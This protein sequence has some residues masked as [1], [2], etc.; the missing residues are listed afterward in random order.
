MHQP[1]PPIDS[2][3]FLWA[4]HIGRT[5]HLDRSSFHR[6]LAGVSP[7]VEQY[8]KG[9]R[10]GRILPALTTLAILEL[11]VSAGSVLS[12]FDG[13]TKLLKV[14]ES[15]SNL[16][17]VFPRS[18]VLARAALILTLDALLLTEDPP[19]NVEIYVR[20]LDAELAAVDWD[21]LEQLSP[22]RAMQIQQIEEDWTPSDVEG[23]EIS[24]DR[25]W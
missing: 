23:N 3:L 1:S 6:Q 17:G 20:I 22:D 18:T 8:A 2:A 10:S 7:L 5:S 21:V 12:C 15:L 11:S 14:W 24:G 19:P 4:A 9:Y 25:L 16:Y 13:R